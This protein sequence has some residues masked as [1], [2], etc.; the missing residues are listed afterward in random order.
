M[1]HIDEALRRAAGGSAPERGQR[2][3]FRIDEYSGEPPSVLDGSSRTARFDRRGGHDE[4]M[5]KVPRGPSPLNAVALTPRVPP[6]QKPE[7]GPLTPHGAGEPDVNAGPGLLQQYR[8]LADLFERART[9]RGLKHLMVTSALA[10]E[11]KARTALHLALTITKVHGT[12]GLLIDADVWQPVI[13]DM[14]GV[15]NQVGLCDLIRRDRTEVPLVQVTSLLRVLPAGTPG[16]QALADLSSERMR[17]L[18][19]ETA[20]HYDWLM[21]NASSVSSSSASV[22]GRFAESV[23]FVVGASTPFPAVERAIAEFGRDSILGTVLIGLDDLLA[24]TSAP[25]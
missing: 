12:R 23:I 22:L 5:S 1:S 24:P 3:P 16:P 8:R 11:D 4:V 25:V 18:L 6:S 21:L 15:S 17:S 13:H 20:G 7:L 2:E 10:E 9:E 14:V 19:R